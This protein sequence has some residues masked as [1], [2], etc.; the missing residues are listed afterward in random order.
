MASISELFHRPAPQYNLGVGGRF[1]AQPLSIREDH[2]RELGLCF[3]DKRGGQY[4]VPSKDMHLRFWSDWY[5][6]IVM[7]LL[8]CMHLHLKANTAVKGVLW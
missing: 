2:L 3:G 6:Y 5:L 1:G 8:F 4:R 7:S